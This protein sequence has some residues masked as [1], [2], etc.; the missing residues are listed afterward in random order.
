MESMK[1]V[2]G[3]MDNF[4]PNEFPKYALDNTQAAVLTKLQN[5][6]HIWDKSIYPSRHPD[7]WARFEGSEN[8]RH[9]A[10]NRKS[11]A[12]DFFP[13]GNVFEFWL[14]MQQMKWGGIGFYFDTRRDN[15]QPGPMIHGDLREERILWFRINGTYYY[16]NV[17]NSEE[18]HYAQLKFFKNIGNYVRYEL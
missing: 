7:G 12:G 14:L 15:L 6:R 9:Y 16:L 18:K 10:V 17:G 11:D 4:S 8:S 1:K 2:I 13:E 5:L 3:Q